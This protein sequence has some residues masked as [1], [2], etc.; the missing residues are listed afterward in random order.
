MLGTTFGG[1]HL[2]CAAGLA[3]LDILKSE[4][5]I[6]NAAAVGAYAIE[7]LKN[8]PGV[9]EVRGMGLM[10][11]VEFNFSTA[12]LRKNLVFE[13]HCFVGSSSEANTLRLLPPLSISKGDVDIL[14]EK[15]KR[16]LV[17][18]IEKEAVKV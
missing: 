17:A 18:I 11:G 16:A 4:N 3:V 10:I 12:A 6:E 7:K 9:K 15:M 14:I 8:L 2:A 13:E 1:N 5:L